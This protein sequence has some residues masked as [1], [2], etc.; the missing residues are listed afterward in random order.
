MKKKRIIVTLMMLLCM[1][2]VVLTAASCTTQPDDTDTDELPPD[3]S[4][5]KE[6]DS[7]EVQGGVEI[8]DLAAYTIVRTEMGKNAEKQAASDLGVLMRESCGLAGIV[9]DYEDAL[10]KEILIGATNRPESKAAQEYA[11]TQVKD[12]QG[13]YYIGVIN[14][15][16]V[17]T[18]I[19]DNGISAAVRSLMMK[20][21]EQIKAGKITLPE[22]Q[23]HTYPNG[24]PTLVVT[25]KGTAGDK[26]VFVSTVN[27]G[28]APYFLDN[29]GEGDVSSTIKAA[30]EKVG[31]MGGGVVYL[32]A[33]VYRLTDTLT[34]PQNV[35]LRGEYVDPDTGDFSK[36]TVLLLDEKKFP[37]NKN[38]LVLNQGSLAQ[39]LAIY[40]EGQSLAAPVAYAATIACAPGALAWEVR[41]CTLINSYDGIS[42]NTRPNGMVTVDNLKGTV[43]HMGYEMQQRADIS[44]GT[45]FTLSPKY[46]A[47]AGEKWNAPAEADIRKYM[48]GNG[49][50]GFYF[51][52]C[53]RDTY[54]NIVL[55][56]FATGMYNC[57]MTRAGLSGSFYNVK[58][59]DAKIGIDAHGIDTRYGLLLVDT[60]IEAS[61]YAA[62]NATVTDSKFC[63]I[64]LLNSDIKGELDG[65]VHVYDSENGVKDTEYKAMS[66]LTPLPGERLFNLADYGVDATGKTD[67][68]DQLQKALDDAATA[69]GGI[70]YVPAG[71]YLLSKAVTIAGD[72]VQLLGCNTGTHTQ[73]GALNT[74]SVLLVTHGR[75]GDENA[76]A[77]ITVSGA[78][79]GV[80]GFSIIYPENGVSHIYFE[81]ESP[82]KYAYCIRA[83]GKGSYVNFMCMIAVSRAV[84]FD[85]ADNFICDR[86]LMTVWDNGIRATDCEG[87]I[88]R[89]HTNGTYHTLG[90][91]CLPVLGSDWAYNGAEVVAKVLDAHI[92]KRLLLVKLE[93]CP[94]IQMTHVFH[95]GATRYMEAVGSTVFVLNGESSR[96]TEMSFVLQ[97]DCDLT[98]INFMRPNPSTYLEQSGENYVYVYNWGAAHY[99]GERIVILEP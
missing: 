82:E 79:S 59:L 37:K 31:S 3:D 24:V 76:Q 72:H 98:V 45:N 80:T 33:G 83:T 87:L 23:L 41:D 65:N 46:W 9:T 51:G 25:D 18:G 69:G 44:I 70:V 43:L 89:I 81:T 95:Y 91:E 54:E 55:D 73:S 71:R 1:L 32:P 40:Y 52:D 8:A 92:V 39:G 66:N 68:S 19:D 17:L 12:G 34:L 22:Q 93:N 14:N 86:L 74:A 11:L 84:H 78:N 42:N 48:K 36:G 7:P 16:I 6:P 67:I 2:A 26:S 57:E 77:A 75:G 63:W 62:I 27:L 38:V 97:G 64:H 29:S 20:Y 15:K 4:D 90:A 58:I 96:L 53:D 60:T 56:G 99:G 47:S 49:S 50:I 21:Q 10:E 61:D 13:W 28:E 30:L 85:G 5:S 94:K 88:S 35:T